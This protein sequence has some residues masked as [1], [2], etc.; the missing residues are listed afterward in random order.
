LRS[1]HSILYLPP[2]IIIPET[3]PISGGRAIP[4]KRMQAAHHGDAEARRFS[5]FQLHKLPLL[6]YRLA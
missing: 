3:Y 1:L 6:R 5:I 4:Q 2:F